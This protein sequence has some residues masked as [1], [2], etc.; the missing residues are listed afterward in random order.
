VTIIQSSS[1]TAY[2]RVSQ[3]GAG[4]VLLLGSAVLYG[5][6][7]AP[8]VL[9][10]DDAMFQRALATGALTNHPLWGL[11][12]RL[13]A[14]LS[15][16]ARGGTEYLGDLAF[17]ANLASAVYAV[18]AVGFLFLATLTLTGNLRAAVAAGAVLAVSHTFWLEAVR[19]EVYTL[20]ML[21][22]LGGLWAFFR[23]RKTPLPLRGP[24]GG[25][26]RQPT[27]HVGWLALGLVFW[28]VGTVNHLLLTV[29]WPGGLWLILSA[30]S[31]AARRKVLVLSPLAVLAGV[32]LLFLA[33]PAFLTQVVPGA[34]RVVLATFNL[35]L[36]RLAMHLAILLYQFPVFGV[37]AVP[38]FVYLWQRDRAAVIS[39]CLMA[40]LTAAFASTHSILE[41]YVFYLPVFALVALYVGTGVGVVTARWPAGRWLVLGLVLIALQVGLY[42]VTPVVVERVA[43]GIIPSRDLPGRRASTFF[44]WPPKHGYLGARQ[45]AQ[46][47]LDLLPADAILIADWTI[48]TPLQYLQDVEGRRRDVLVVQVDP[49]GMQTIHE[50]Q[51]PRGGT[52][53]LPRTGGTDAERLGRRPLFLANADPR[54]YPMDEFHA[55]FE[56]QPVG[57]VWALLLREDSPRTE[58]ETEYQPP[59]GGTDAERLR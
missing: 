57:Q 11:L 24:R 6:T 51:P 30:L 47:T 48:F 3:L 4:G 29:A 53:Y 38:G 41:S 23:W 26:L 2:D 1:D 18:G 59:R 19:A 8:T 16:P 20:H 13:F 5:C 42:R 15:L 35:S 37:L 33:E 43:P 17:R 12:A 7:L 40:V 25:R 56:L 55:W 58:D 46:D 34:A 9:W 39:L 10:G 14:R 45:F 21:L 52:E 36:S 28:G 49:A 50:N 27:W 22:F 32:I 54:Y 44:L 31:P